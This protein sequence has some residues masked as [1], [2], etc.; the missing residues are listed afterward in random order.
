MATPDITKDEKNRISYCFWS[1]LCGGIIG[2]LDF[3]PKYGLEFY[4]LGYFCIPL[5]ITPIGIAIYK[6]NLMNIKI[7]IKK[8][9]V[10]SILIATIT[11]IYLL[12]IMIIEHIFRGMIGYH[13]IIVSLLSAFTIA[14]IFNP[15]RN[16]IHNFIDRVFLGKLPQEI[17]IENKLL[18][19]E[20]ERSERLKIANTLALG[21]AHEVK[22]PLTT[23]KTFTEFLPQHYDDKEFL[24]KFSKIVPG[25]IERVNDIIKQLLQFSRPTPPALQSSSVYQLM[26]DILVFL[27][28]DLLKHKIKLNESYEDRTLKINADPNQIKQALLNILLNAID[29]MPGGGT[30]TIEAKKNE[31]LVEL[32]IRDSGCGIA[33]EDLKHIF[34]PFYSKKESGTGLGLAVTHQ[35]IKNHNGRIEVESELN[36][37]TIFKIFFRLCNKN[38]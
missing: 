35:I 11:G 7:A 36:K 2:P 23:L 4:P 26:Q 1:F 17:A 10:Y 13:S 38:Q 30:I 27:N 37:G 15:L 33:K 16:I 22:N 31:D 25:E 9:A 3:L 14:I 8:G 6:H 18:K 29:A 28:N 5:L 20:L 34:D 32:S 12:L 19:Q 21:L 24:E